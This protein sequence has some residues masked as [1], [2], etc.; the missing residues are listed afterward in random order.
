M[1]YFFLGCALLVALLLLGRLIVRAN[2]T[3][4]AGTVR[5]V[6]GVALFGVAGF[7]ALRGAMPLAIPLAAFALSLVAGGGRLGGFGGSGEKSKGQTSHVQ[8][9]RLEMELDHDT[10]YMD[11]KCLEGRFAGRALSSLSER[12]ALE[13]YASFESDGLKEAA[14][15]E[16]YLDWRVP[17]WRH[18]AEA[19]SAGAGTGGF[20]K[21]RMS[22]E[23]ARAV[24]E[25]P[26]DASEEDIR[27][28][29]RRL[30]MKLHPDQGGST[31]LAAR[32]NEAKDVLIGR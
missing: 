20:S 3:Q 2:P 15:M 16:A 19:A 17:D 24:L 1:V 4:L 5:K 13:L 11:G 25:V 21:G 22:V 27:Q 7:L 9:E 26:P 6:G 23:E 10:G 28:A 30:M 12:E 14:L 18:K 29:H 31:Y 32:I 8:T